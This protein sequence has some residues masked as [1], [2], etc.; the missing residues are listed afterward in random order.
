MY[1]ANITPHMFLFAFFRDLPVTL[2]PKTFSL[3]VILYS[4]T[5]ISLLVRYYIVAFSLPNKLVF[6]PN[7]H[8]ASVSSLL[9]DI[10]AYPLPDRPFAECCLT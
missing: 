8:R 1:F 6:D 2:R 9:L 7:V 4:I 10:Y 3:H 5:G